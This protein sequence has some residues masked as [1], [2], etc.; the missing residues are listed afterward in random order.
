MPIQIDVPK[1][2]GLT[3]PGSILSPYDRVVY[4]ILADEIGSIIEP[5]LD[6]TRVFSNVLESEDT[7][8]KMFR[9]ANECWREMESSRNRICEE[10]RYPYV[11]K[12]DVACY[13]E[14]IYQHNLCNL[15]RGSGC[16][17]RIINQLE[18]VLSQFTEKDSHG[19]LLYTS[20]AADD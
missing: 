5:Q 19:C 10:G 4:Q 18:N 14:R 3:R 15:L 12:T 20:D 8:H 9:P 11:I 13:F 2:S 16:D 6:R 17:T 1:S 7:E